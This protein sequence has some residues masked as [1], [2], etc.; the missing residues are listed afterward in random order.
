M[1]LTTAQ[2]RHD[3]PAHIKSTPLVWNASWTGEHWRVAPI[4]FLPCG[5]KALASI[6]IPSGLHFNPPLPKG[7]N[8]KQKV[9]LLGLARKLRTGCQCMNSFGCPVPPV[10]NLRPS[11]GVYMGK[12]SREAAWECWC[13]NG[14]KVELNHPEWGNPITKEHIWCT[15][16][17]KWILGLLI[18]L[19]FPK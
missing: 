19:I 14:V 18:F 7:G 2:Q 4:P 3:K 1:S 10:S 12:H 11:F 5:D 9:T 8:L 13:H 16:T 17:D 6:C 15:L